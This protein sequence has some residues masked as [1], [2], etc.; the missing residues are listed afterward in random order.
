MTE[1]I[2]TWQDHED[3]GDHW[4]PVEVCWDVIKKA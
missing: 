3:A 2:G 4:R 1:K